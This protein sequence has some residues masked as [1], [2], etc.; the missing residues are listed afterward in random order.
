MEVKMIFPLWHYCVLIHTLGLWFSAILDTHVLILL[1]SVVQV[2]RYAVPLLMHCMLTLADRS[3]KSKTDS[4]CLIPT[5]K[6]Q[7]IQ[8]SASFCD[9]LLFFLF[10]FEINQVKV[11]QISAR[12]L[13]AWWQVCGALQSKLW[14]WWYSIQWNV[15]VIDE[16]IN[17]L[18]L[19]MIRAGAKAYAVKIFMIDIFSMTAWEILY[20]LPQCSNPQWSGLYIVHVL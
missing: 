8:T 2:C 13:F 16:L 10:L 19:Y 9:H 11:K 20:W 1:H 3:F 12:E 5:L 18:I 15:E 6:I 4:L 7:N 17:H 14:R